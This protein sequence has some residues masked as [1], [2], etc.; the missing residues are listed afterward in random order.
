MSNQVLIANLMIRYISDAQNRN[1]KASMLTS[2]DNSHS[3]S[4]LVGHSHKLKD[5]DSVEF[6]ER[7]SYKANTNIH[8]NM[9]RK[10]GKKASSVN[11][12]NTLRT[13]IIMSNIQNILKTLDNNSKNN[14]T[15]GINV[16]PGAVVGSNSGNNRKSENLM[17]NCKITDNSNTGQNE[18][19]KALV[20][21]SLNKYGGI[22]LGLFNSG[23]KDRALYSNEYGGIQKSNP[24]KK[25][26][27][28]EFN[29]TV[30]VTQNVIEG[31]QVQK[32][33]KL[34]NLNIDDHF[35]ESVEPTG[36]MSVSKD[37]LRYKIS[38]LGHGNLKISRNKPTIMT[39]FHENKE[40]RESVV[41]NENK[42]F[43]ALK[44]A[45]SA[46]LP[47][48]STS[49]SN[50]IAY[51]NIHYNNKVHS[52]KFIHPLSDTNKQL[53]NPFQKFINNDIP[54][55]TKQS[56]IPNIIT[57][58]NKRENQTNQTTLIGKNR[59]YMIRTNSNNVINLI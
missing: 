57:T 38:N 23:S 22:H 44:K 15:A 54:S 1:Q 50:I 39:R 29:H 47:E 46:I 52:S 21:S 13:S 34:L 19:R 31:I 3:A 4:K 32:D 18:K 51:S 28:A 37:D 53:K 11:K 12:R 27:V 58:H 26:A 56:G 20:Q 43:R 41:N 49:S 40:N 35:G 55:S 42:I 2:I 25:S 9:K 5:G 59:K 7:N 45:N 48:L 17:F 8:I 36:V 6:I 24:S 10:N 14:F 16:N 30:G 33:Q